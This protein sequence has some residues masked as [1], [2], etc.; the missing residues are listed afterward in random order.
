MSRR[1]SL[2]PFSCTVVVPYE[3]VRIIGSC[4][5]SSNLRPFHDELVEGVRI[6]FFSLSLPLFSIS[7]DL[8]RC[9]L[10]P[11]LVWCLLLF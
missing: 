6:M 7:V 4:L 8:E 9:G 1:N 3:W 2:V 10:S 5:L 11:L